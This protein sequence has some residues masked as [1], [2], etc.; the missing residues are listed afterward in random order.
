MSRIILSRHDDNTVHV[1]VGYDHPCGGAF[2]QEYGS[3]SEVTD[4]ETEMTRLEREG[5]EVPIELETLVETDIKRQGGFGRG[6]P[7]VSFYESVPEE[8][9]SLVTPEVMQLLF[10]HA[11]DPDSGYVGSPNH[12]VTDLTRK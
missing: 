7:L 8:L 9:R 6:I 4:A 10:D 3:K 11:A 2:W 12:G 1:V 5:Q